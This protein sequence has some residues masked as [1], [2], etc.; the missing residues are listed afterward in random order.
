M[1]PED[2]HVHGEQPWKPPERLHLTDDALCKLVFHP[3]QLFALAFEHPVN[4]NT[5]PARNHLAHMFRRNRLFQQ[6]TLVL[7]AFRLG[8]FLFKLRNLAISKLTSLL[9]FTV[10]LCSGQSIACFF[11]L[12]LE[13]GS[14]TELLLFRLPLGGQ[15]S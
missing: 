13:I 15:F 2:P 4:R 6:R 3:Q 12:T 1:D 7:L 11:K 8:E 14:K 9:E 10:A 5:R